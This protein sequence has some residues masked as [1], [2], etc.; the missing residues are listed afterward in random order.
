MNMFYEQNVDKFFG[1]QEAP[2]HIRLTVNMK[3]HRGTRSEERDS[4]RRYSRLL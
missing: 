4:Q 1:D 3:G 2:A